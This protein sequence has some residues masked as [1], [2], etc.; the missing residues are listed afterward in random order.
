MTVDPSDLYRA[1]IVEHSKHPRHEGPLDG[2]THEAKGIN[3]LCGDRVTVR[4]R[5]D[6]GTIVEAAFEARGCAI[7]KASASILTEA[8][9]GLEVGTA[10]ARAA[11]LQALV[12]G[13]EAD[14]GDAALAPLAGVRQFPSRKRCATLAWTTLQEALRS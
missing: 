8:V 14:E 1:Q 4:L 7:A 10:E 9:T 13:A 2:A 12:D 6:G 3:P 11:R 5:V